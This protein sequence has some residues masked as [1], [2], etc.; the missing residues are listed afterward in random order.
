M[1]TYI[2]MAVYTMA[3]WSL[4]MYKVLVYKK[5]KIINLQAKNSKH[6][7]RELSKPS[8][9]ENKTKQKNLI[10]PYRNN[11]LKKFIEHSSSIQ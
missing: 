11:V 5:T 10:F 6:N 9:D 7:C 3:H 2:C 1:L 4:Y 8:A